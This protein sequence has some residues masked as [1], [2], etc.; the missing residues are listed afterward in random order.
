MTLLFSAGDIEKPLRE[1]DRIK[2]GEFMTISLR[3]G[4]RVGGRNGDK[5]EKKLKRKKEFQEN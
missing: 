2:K 4:S 1:K 5:K 3:K